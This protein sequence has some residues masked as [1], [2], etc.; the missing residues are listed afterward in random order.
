MRQGDLKAM[1]DWKQMIDESYLP[2][3]LPR[4]KFPQ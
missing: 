4:I 2:A 1:P 3:S